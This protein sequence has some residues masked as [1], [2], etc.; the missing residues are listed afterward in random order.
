MGQTNLSCIILK[1]IYVCYAHFKEWRS[2]NIVRHA[3][4]DTLIK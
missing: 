4:N 1:D 3:I 2:L